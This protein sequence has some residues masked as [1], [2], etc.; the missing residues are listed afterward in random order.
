MTSFDYRL[1]PRYLIK[2]CSSCGA[3]YTTDYCCS[4][5]SLVDKIIYDLNKAP[6]SPH[7]H[8]LSS[9]QR[10]CFHCKDV[11]GDG[12]VCQRCTCTRCGSGLC[13]GLCLICKHNQHSLNTSLSISANSSQSPSQINHHC[14]Y[15]CGNPL[16]GIF[17][18]QCT[19][20]LCGNGAHY[21]YNCPPKVPIIPD[22]EPFNNHTIKEL[23]PTVQSFDPKSDLVYNSPNFFSPSLQPLGYSYEFCGNNAYYGQDGSL[24]SPVI[25]QPPQEMSIQEMEDLKKQYLDEMKCLINSEY[26]YEIKIA[27]LKENFN[28]MSI[29]IRKK[30]KL[31][32][33]EQWA[34]LSTYPLKRFNSFCYDDDDED[35]TIAVTPSLSTEELDNSLS[36]EDEH[37]DTISATKSDE[38]IKFIVENLITIPSESEG[39]PDNMCDVPF[40]DNSP[41][42]DE[43]EIVI[44]EVGGIDDD[45]LL[46]IQD[47]I[48]REKLLNVNILISKIEALN[49]NPTSSSDF[50]TKS[51]STSLNSLLEETN[52]FDNSLPEF[53][54]FCFDVEEI[55]NGSTT[56]HSDI[57]LPGYKAFYDDHVKEISS[58]NPTTHSDSPLYDSFIFDLSINLFHPADRSDF[59]EFADDFIHFISSP[60]YDCF[61]FKIEP[62]SGDFTMDVVE[63]ISPT[64]ESKE[65]GQRVSSYVLKMKGYIDNL[66]RLGNPVT[67][68]LSVSLILIGLRKEYDGFVQNY[69]MHSMRMTVN[70]LH[71]MLKLHEQTLQKTTLM[72][73]MLFEPVKSRKYLAE[74]LKKKKNVASGAGG[75]GIFVI[76]LNTILNR[77][78]IY[79][80][81][82][83]T[84]ICNT[85]QGLRA[86][87]KL[88]SG[89]LSLY[90]G[91]DQRE[92]VEAIG[93]FNLCLP[94]GL[95]IVLN[96]C[97]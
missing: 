8:T 56:T 25:H 37:L 35:Y 20:Q 30:E 59:Y 68:G 85:T 67:L 11:L 18:H 29:E 6:D 83:G 54:T 10:H 36:M 4:N 86:S 55:S 80:T 16:E 39:I 7:L 87:R 31:Q 47:D 23:P 40:H 12:E 3:L 33:L 51:S 62:N 70:E 65:E 26:H 24:Q 44:P 48:L 94:S 46:T 75:S 21:G 78:W 66:E 14:C 97:H 82:C 61:L 81:G 9:N 19:C 49:D 95:E 64:K 45:I 69:N 27:E 89:A 52:N 41:P 34:N 22:L 63:D 96:N 91:N 92:A 60:E 77:S 72:L 84:H 38:F 5:G 13:K 93:V 15:G 79:D 71:A 88:K 73:F 2:E 17:Y 50:K 58:G 76:E 74:F 32:Q 42:L 43:M 28:G 53:E 1:N 90:V 57:S